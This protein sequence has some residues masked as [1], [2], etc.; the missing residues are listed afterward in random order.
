MSNAAGLELLGAGSMHHATLLEHIQKTKKATT[1]PFGVNV[2][3]LYPEIDTLMHIITEEKVPVVFTSA[4][5]PK[6][7]TNILK[8]KGINVGHVVAS[9]KFARKCEDAGVDA[10]VAEGFQSATLDN[11][12]ASIL[13]F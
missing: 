6:T 11:E 13:L 7:W 1:K 8:A 10:I 4:C 3:L 12:Y 5:N 2:P 9:S